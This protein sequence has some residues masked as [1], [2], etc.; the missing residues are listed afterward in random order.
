MIVNLAELRQ[1]RLSPPPPEFDPADPGRRNKLS[2]EQQKKRAKDL[3]HA[4]QAN[5]A[6]AIVRFQRHSPECLAGQQRPRL[7]DAQEVIARENGFRKWTGLKAHIDRI[8]VEQQVIREGRPSALDAGSRTLHIRCGQ[9]I[10]HDLAVGGFSGDFLSFADPYVLGPVPRTLSLEDFVR[11]RANY[12]APGDPQCFAGLYAAYRDLEKASEYP[13]VNIW[14]EH[15]SHDQLILARLLHFFS[16][17]SRRPARLRMINVTHFPGVER[18]VGLG[19]LPAQALRLLWNDFEDVSEAQLLL[20]TRVWNAVT[21]P[22]PEGLIEIIKTGT[23]VLPTI[24]PAVARHL[25]EL[26]SAAN[27]LSLSEQLTLQILS[28]KGGMTATRLWGW[29]NG[30][31]EPLPF[32]GDTGY[33]AVLAALSNADE[34]AISIDG[35][36][37]RSDEVDFSSRVEL[38][39]F[40]ERLLRNEADWLAAHPTDRWIGGV[41][42]DPQDRRNWRFDGARETVKRV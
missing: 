10:M 41:R 4:V 35:G 16:D 7:H 18:F 17:A 24:G 37:A 12:L 3:L 13:V 31:Y 22:S 38:L 29:Y 30:R 1:Q 39:P 26:P 36:G 5:D 42:I 20:G 19:Q 33:W 8:S 2:L 28:D 21:S 34:P 23:E 25:R 14:M 9:D 15:D 32:M 11:I 40:G 6:D 27:G